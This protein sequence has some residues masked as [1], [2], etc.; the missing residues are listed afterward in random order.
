MF[1]RKNICMYLK[2]KQI[3]VLETNFVGFFVFL[4]KNKVISCFVLFNTSEYILYNVNE[5]SCIC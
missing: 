1:V 5:L 4:L 2:E 3:E